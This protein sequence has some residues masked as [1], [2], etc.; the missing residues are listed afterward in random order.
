MNRRKFYLIK[1]DDDGWRAKHPYD[2]LAEHKCGLPGVRCPVC[3]ATWGTAGVHYPTVPC[4]RFASFGG[5]VKRWPVSLNEFQ[6]LIGK[7]RAIL[8]DDRLLKPGTRFG[9]LTGRGNGELGDFVW[10]DSWTPLIRKET[11]LTLKLRGIALQGAEANLRFR[12]KEAP[13]LIEIEAWPIARLHPSC[14]P[15]PPPKPCSACGRL[16]LSAPKRIVVAGDSLDDRVPI[17]RLVELPTFL[18]VNE[19]LA[20]AIQD[21][22]L[23]DVRLSEAEVG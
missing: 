7:V 13:T 3:Q 11:F 22:E 16:G 8:S 23:R 5:L 18:L 15:D 6:V 21:L 12:K 17:Q 14:L 10:P 20:T 9:P 19:S 2:V 4:E 1:P